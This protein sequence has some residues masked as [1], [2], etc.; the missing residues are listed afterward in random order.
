MRNKQSRQSENDHER[1]MDWVARVRAGDQAAFSEV[2]NAFFPRVYAFILQAD[3]RPG[4]GRG[5]D[6]GDLRP[7][8]SLLRLLRGPLEP[9][10]LDLRHRPQRLLPL[11]PPLLALDGRPE[12]RPRARRPPERCGHR[13]PPRCDPSA[14]ALRRGPRGGT[15]AGPSGDLP[16]SLCG[17]PVDPGD[18]Q[19]GGQVERGREGRACAEVATCWSTA[20]RSST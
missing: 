4:G 1:D 17:E 8:L 14:R 7:A 12:G 16:T 20:S 5:P 18:R 3:R 10:D 2:Y 9:A 19:A 11:L 6:P 15:A 13:A